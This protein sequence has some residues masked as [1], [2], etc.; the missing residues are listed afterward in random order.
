MLGAVPLHHIFHPS[1]LS[2]KFLLWCDEVGLVLMME[3]CGS[4]PV[5]SSFIDCCVCLRILGATVQ[6]G[7]D[8]V[9]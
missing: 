8:I 2:G 1:Y 6:Q 3:V 5:C 7:H 9:A 4:S